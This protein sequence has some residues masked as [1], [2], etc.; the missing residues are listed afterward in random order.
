MKY[1]KS[2]IPRHLHLS[3]SENQGAY[4]WFC[5]IR[6]LLGPGSSITTWHA[7]TLKLF[8]WIEANTVYINFV[9]TIRIVSSSDVPLQSNIVGSLLQSWESSCVTLHKSWN[10]RWF[11]RNLLYVASLKTSHVM[12]SHKLTLCCF[13]KESHYAFDATVIFSFWYSRDKCTASSRIFHYSASFWR[14]WCLS[15]PIMSLDQLL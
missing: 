13:A 10:L 12:I 2:K 9:W 6:C 4:T 14:G 7:K 8:T 3:L 11:Q 1:L 5:A 15:M